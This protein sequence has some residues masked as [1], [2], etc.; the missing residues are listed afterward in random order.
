MA[1]KVALFAVLA[2]LLAVLSPVAVA[3]PQEVPIYIYMASDGLTF[4]VEPGQVAV[5]FYGWWACNKGL[6]QAYINGSYSYVEVLLD[7]NPILTSDQADDLWLPIAPSTSLICDCIQQSQ[8]HSA[9]WRYVLAGLEPG[10]Y[11]LRSIFTPAHPLPDGCE[12]EDGKPCIYT[13][14]NYYTETLNTIIVVD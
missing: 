14:D 9:Y 1:K 4:T 5:P 7:G 2:L 10:E 8:P 6:V 3:Q 13:P 11:V 12:C